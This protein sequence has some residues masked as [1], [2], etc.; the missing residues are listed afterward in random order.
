MG[1]LFIDI[2]LA[3]DTPL[4]DRCGNCNRCQQACPTQAFEAPH[5]LDARKCL[6]YVTIES[7]EDIPIELR[8]KMGNRIYGCD[9]CLRVCPW[10]RFA[11]PCQTT[12]LQPA[13]EFMQMTREEWHNLSEETYRKLFKGSAVKRAKYSGLVRNI[14]AVGYPNNSGANP[15]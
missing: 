13:P 6:S 2:E 14:E 9:E 12:E 8:K 1:E 10:T 3:Y 4:K 7:R 5:K 15:D 11:I